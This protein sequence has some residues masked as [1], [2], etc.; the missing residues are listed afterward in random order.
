M[1]VGILKVF[2]KDGFRNYGFIR[3]PD[4]DIYVHAH[5]FRDAWTAQP[6][7]RLIFDLER[8]KNGRPH[9]ANVRSAE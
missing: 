9:A 2:F 3:T 1:A 4:G 5:A 6:G 7:D 8:G